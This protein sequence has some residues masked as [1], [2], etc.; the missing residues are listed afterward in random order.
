MPHT[1]VSQSHVR[2]GHCRTKQLYPG[3]ALCS[4][5]MLR[6]GETRPQHGVAKR[7]CWHGAGNQHARSRV[8]RNLAAAAAE[9][10][11]HTTA[12]AQKRGSCPGLSGGLHLTCVG[13]ATTCLQAGDSDPFPHRLHTHTALAA[14]AR[15]KAH[16]DGTPGIAAAAVVERWNIDA[17]PP[18][19]LVASTACPIRRAWPQLDAGA[20]AEAGG[21]GWCCCR[22]AAALV[23][24][25][26]LCSTATG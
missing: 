23:V 10:L 18:A 21:V 5:H 9:A 13:G 11:T 19:V 24:C 25:W 3:T 12:A 1:H 7:L 17:A 6:T 16:A 20:G 4:T 8:S 15:P 22:A 14:G 2:R 26:L